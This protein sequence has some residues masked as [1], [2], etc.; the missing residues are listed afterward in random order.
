MSYNLNA[1]YEP[2]C[3]NRLCISDNIEDIKPTGP[4]DLS[5]LRSRLRSGCKNCLRTIVL[6]F[7]NDPMY[8]IFGENTVF[9]N[10]KVSFYSGRLRRQPRIEHKRMMQSILVKGPVFSKIDRNQDAPIMLHLKSFISKDEWDVL[11][12]MFNHLAVQCELF[13]KDI[14][15]ICTPTYFCN[16]SKEAPI[17]IVSPTDGVQQVVKTLFQDKTLSCHV[18]FLN[19]VV[20]DGNYARLPYEINRAVQ[21]NIWKRG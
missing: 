10:A 3:S 20:I 11:V 17:H 14:C 6:R 1:E 8:W 7:T 15:S 4:I 12:G 21:E 19:R 9:S 18:S 16:A 13:H 2:V 5:D